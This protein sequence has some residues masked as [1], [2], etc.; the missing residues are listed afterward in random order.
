MA[1]Y[2]RQTECDLENYSAVRIDKRRDPENR[3]EALEDIDSENESSR[4]GAENTKDICRPEISAPLCFKVDME[5]KT[6]D[7][8]AGRKSADKIR[9]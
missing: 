5:K 7:Q 1:G 8:E 3:S 2:R 9:Q 6:A 4:P